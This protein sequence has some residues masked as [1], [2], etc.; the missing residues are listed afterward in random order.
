MRITMRDVAERAGVSAATVSHVLNNTR[1]VTDETRQR[2]MQTIEQMGYRPDITARSFKTGKKN[3][4]GIIVPDIAN[5]IWA[6]IIEEVEAVLSSHGYR[7]LICNTKETEE[8]ELD[9]IRSLTSGLVDG[10]IIA[11]TLNDY[12]QLKSE[13]PE[14]LPVVFIDRMLKN[15]PH[16]M[17]LPQDAPA[18][19]KGMEHLIMEEGHRRIG[20]ITGLMR[21]STSTD[22]LNA[23]QNAMQD[24]GLKIEQGFIQQGNSMAKSSVIL[25]EALLQQKC[26]AI[27][28]SN[29]IMADDVLFYLSNHGIRLGHDISILGQGIEG[30]RNYGQRR[31]NLFIQPTSEIGQTAG[32]TILERLANP[33]LPIRQVIL[34]SIFE[35]SFII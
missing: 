16:D 26:T 9:H 11:S 32:Q 15:C 10:L 23:Y 3:V 21:I 17:I 24:Y 28:V 14:D 19:Y 34:N 35:H 13:L 31:M 4:I 27:V 25:I 8:R 2:V 5:P 29:N 18:I 1:F 12:T 6:I 20:F 33:S 7:L 22:R 30:Q